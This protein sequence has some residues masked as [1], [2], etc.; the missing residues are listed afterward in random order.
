MKILENLWQIG[1]GDLTAPGDAAIYL[2][3]F[4]D[5]AALVDAGCGPGHERLIKNISECLPASVK[6]T[7]LF[8][9]HCHFDHTGG[10][11]AVRRQYGCKIVAHELDSVFLKK[12]DNRVTAA[13]WY[14]TKMK[15]FKVDYKISSQKEIIEVGNGQVQAYHCPGHSPGSLIYTAE[16]DSKKVIFGQD[17]HGPLHPTLLS[18]RQD[19]KRCL[20]FILSLKAD[21]LCEG[22]FGIF[23]GK[24]EIDQFVRS[25]L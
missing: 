22:H 9:T 4:D 5:E 12:A 15:P 3:R 2:A 25:F 18:N 21:I 24:K 11:E 14:R 13:R 20:Q 17:V 6:I 19:Y 7:Y 1:G 16:L 10:A 23:R 8:L